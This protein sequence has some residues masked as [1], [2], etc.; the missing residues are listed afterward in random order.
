MVYDRHDPSNDVSPVHSLSEDQLKV[1]SPGMEAFYDR[2]LPLVANKLGKKFGAKVG[3]QS[4]EADV[5]GPLR[6]ASDGSRYWLADKDGKRVSPYYDSA[7]KAMD[8]RSRNAVGKMV[9][10]IDITPAMR[11][12]VMQGQPL[13][14]PKITGETGSPRPITPEE[15]KAYERVGRAIDPVSLRDRFAALKQ[16][17]WKKVI[18]E[19]LDPYIGV[20]ANDPDGYMALRLA[21][22]SG[23]AAEI[24]KTEGTLKFNGSAY[25]IKDHNGGVEHSVIRPLH[26]EQDDF[27]WWVAANRAEALSKEDREHL[28]TPEDIAVL[29]K[30]N[31]GTLSFDYEL[32]NG[33]TTRSREAAYTD[34]L[35]KYDAFNKNAMELATESGILDRGK[36]SALWSNPFYVP[37]FREAKDD[38]HFVGPSVSSGFVKQYAFKTLKG[39]T[40]KL[41]ND[42]WANAFGNWEH[43]ID[44]SIRNT[45][46]KRVLESAADPANGA[47]MKL[48][49]QDVAKM[50]DKE[51][52]ANTVWVMDKGEKQSYLVTDPFL[53]KAI[54]ALDFSG[55]KGGLMKI[56]GGFA[57]ML[58]AGV[59]ADPRF[60]LRVAIRDAEQAVATAPM[61]YNLVDNVITG[62]KMNDLPGALQNVARAVA[63][64]ELHRLNMSDEALSA[65]AGGAAMRLGSGQEGGIRKTNLSTMLNTPASIDNFWHY[66]STVARAYK[67]ASA[68]GEDVN[69]FAL[70]HKLRAEGIPHDQA[71]FAGRDLEDFTLKGASPIVRGLTTLV[72]FMNAWA[73][74]LYKVARSAA[75]SD[76]NVGAAVAGS[77]ARSATKRVAIVLGAT[78]ALTL[79][80]DAIYKDD[81]DYKKRSESDRNTYF[82]FKFGNTQFQIPMGFEIA[83]LSR[84]AANGM[85]AFFD[86]E[87]TPRR[88]ANSALTMIGTNMA[89]NPTPQIIAPLVDVAMN[90]GRT[91]HPITPMG[92]ENLQ[93]EDQYNINSTLAAR[94][95]S[96]AVNPVMRAVAGQQQTGPSPLQI[97]YLVNAYTGWLGSFVLGTADRFV[98]S[99]TS[100]PT[101]PAMDLWNFATGG[102]VSTQ[103]TPQSRYVDLMYQQAAGINKAYGTYEDL[104]R[105]GRTDEAT[106]FFNANREQMQQHQLIAG[107]TAAEA[108]AN[109]NIRF[110]ENRRDLSAEQKQVQI[111]Q[112][113]AIK[114]RSAESVFGAR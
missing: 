93:S 74:G 53:F 104:M 32:S 7:A 10:S 1:G 15:R 42:L 22:S 3:E 52:K 80:L 31:Q 57:R 78:T 73:Q 108:T 109:R 14:S 82:W 65:V 8:A 97:D 40:E 35:R 60:M 63:G 107:V 34:S 29:K 13:F 77:I 11:E 12:S 49:P 46:A 100:E 72:P 51:Q 21:N 90:E 61:S 91:G 92:M 88:L 84:M 66:L 54:T 79:A 47:A 30:T 26:G 25:D 110:I 113:N 48:S 81:E 111:M 56:A 102:M 5:L 96:S 98:R 83:A 19:T 70:Y 94:G 76:K 55:Y 95:I 86:K 69:R 105:R 106:Q 6:V 67:E 9:H 18:R 85:E 38:S 2:Q 71:A 62:F 17:F 44:A 68:Q 36:V 114:N 64:Q 50:S 58:R 33:K 75:N 28:F 41:H 45:A 27:I 23:A 59:T 87:M 89:M 24:F 20:K 43:M 37:F 4:V 99:L 16:D 101:R 112:I 103:Q 39:G